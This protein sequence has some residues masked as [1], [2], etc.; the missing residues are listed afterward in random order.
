MKLFEIIQTADLNLLY[1]LN[2]KLQ[3]P[4]MDQFWLFVTQMHKNKIVLFGVVPALIGWMFYIYG[5]KAIR[6]LLALIAAV[7]IADTV[8]YR[9]V[10]SVVDRPRPFMNAETSMWLRKIGQAHGRSFP[11]NHA[12]NC[13]AGAFVL[14][15]Y[16][17]RRAV[18]FY[19]VA[20]LVGVSRVALGLHYPSDVLVGS[21]IGI[22]IGWLLME[23]GL[24]RLPWFARAESKTERANRRFAGSQ[25]NWRKKSKRLRAD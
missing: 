8:A 23:K 12:A 24:S 19:T 2:V 20:I 7:A 25:W 17:R 9:G 22:F 14:A 4:Y 5:L 3:N 21:M 1:V 16:M 11:S 18:T 10:K 15:W 13:F 6:P